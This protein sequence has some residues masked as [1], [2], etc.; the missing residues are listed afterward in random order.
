MAIV[1]E[2]NVADAWMSSVVEALEDTED[3]FSGVEDDGCIDTSAG[4]TGTVGAAGAA[5]TL[6]ACA[7]GAEG[8]V[9]P[10]LAGDEESDGGDGD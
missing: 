7:T 2:L 4:N 5:E 10:L 8:V 1:E 9:P 6:P 3:G